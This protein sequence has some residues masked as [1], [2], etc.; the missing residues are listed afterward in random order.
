MQ[1]GIVKR[2][3]KMA[4]QASNAALRL[5]EK[6]DMDKEKA[7]ESALSQIERAFGKGSIMRLG[8]QGAAVEIPKAI[9]VVMGAMYFYFDDDLGL[10]APEMDNST[11]GALKWFSDKADSYITQ[12]ST[13]RKLA[14]AAQ[15]IVNS[16]HAV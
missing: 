7:L 1:A 8:E 4:T 14:N 16:R 6:N 9:Q 3:S 15:A 10:N 2:G 11:P 13:A 5:V 12:P